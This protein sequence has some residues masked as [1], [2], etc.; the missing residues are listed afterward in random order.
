M[1]LSTQTENINFLTASFMC[2]MAQANMKL[3]QAM[4][5]TATQ[6]LSELLKNLLTSLVQASQRQFKK[7]LKTQ[8]MAHTDL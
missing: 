1:A 4:E 2:Q 7:C 6:S 5:Q 3:M 8:F